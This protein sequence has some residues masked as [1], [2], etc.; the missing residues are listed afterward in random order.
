MNHNP[1][2]DD[3]L[4]IWD[5]S[6]RGRYQP[7]VNSYS[8][9]FELQ[10]QLGLDAV[11]GYYRHPGACVDDDYIDDRIYE[12]TGQHP[13]NIQSY[14][15]S[16]GARPLDHVINPELIAN[17]R[18]LDV[19]C[20]MGRWTRVMQRLGAESVI[21][22]DMSASAL[23]SVSRFNDRVL[24]ANVMTLVSD[25]PELKRSSDFTTLWGVAM[26]THDPSEAVAQASATVAPGGAL[27]LM[28]YAPEGIHGT[29]LTQCQRRKFHSLESA[30]ARLNFVDK[31]FH[32]RWDWSYSLQ[33]NLKN[34]LRNLRG[35]DKGSQIG[36]LD[37]L[38]PFYNW[39]ISLQTISHWM[40]EYGFKH[41]QVLNENEPVK[42]AYHVL[43]QRGSA[44]E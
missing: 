19:G 2:F 21:S 34:V 6:Y 23:Q 1:T 32:R 15:S 37:M 3:G 26:H 18:C 17:K 31:V 4:V 8:A 40:D 42:C 35:L 30:E 9:E 33:D 25:N 11:E 29:R 14:D 44:H 38:E 24:E 10:W 12:W 41:W 36:V 16:C 27:Y 22:V 43:A 7:P 39:V 5:D 28:V 13:R 20:G